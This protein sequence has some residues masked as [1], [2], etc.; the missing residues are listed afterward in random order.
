MTPNVL[1]HSRDERTGLTVNSGAEALAARYYHETIGQDIW[2]RPD[3]R[4]RGVKDLPGLLLTI[5]PTVQLTE[6]SNGMPVFLDGSV[7]LLLISTFV[8]EI[9]NLTELLV[10]DRKNPAAYEIH[11]QVLR[12]MATLPT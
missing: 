11:I 1:A 9:Y 3:Y 6:S 12:T 2:C 4:R 5:Y 7:D 8:I 10:A